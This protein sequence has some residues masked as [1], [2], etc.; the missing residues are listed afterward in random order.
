MTGIDGQALSL[1]QRRVRLVAWVLLVASAAAGVAL[2][3]WHV[4]KQ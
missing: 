1:W 4:R 3:T 2:A